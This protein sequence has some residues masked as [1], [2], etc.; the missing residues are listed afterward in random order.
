MSAEDEASEDEASEDDASED[1]S[2]EDDLDDWEVEQAEALGA[3]GEIRPEVVDRFLRAPRRSRWFPPLGDGR[4]GVILPESGRLMVGR[5][6][7][8]LRDLLLAGDP[9]L[10]R[11]YPTAYPDDAAR[12]AEYASFAHDQLLMARLEALDLV[13]RT[14]DTK[15]LTAAELTAW[16]QVLNQARLVLGTRLDIAEDDERYEDPDHPDAIPLFI[17]HQLGLFVGDMVDALHTQLGQS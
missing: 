1:E 15:V 9:S 7:E 4:F 3:D 17:Y 12:N 14:V 13:E 11:L 16:M 2:W 5:M 6:V 10:Q 8:D